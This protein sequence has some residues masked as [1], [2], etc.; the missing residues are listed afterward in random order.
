MLRLV[1][2]LG[3]VFAG[4]ACAATPPP[5]VAARAWLVADLT[6]GHVL[7][8]RKADERFEPASLTKLMTAYVVFGA[9]HER[10]LALTQQVPVSHHAWRAPGAKMFLDP[11]KPGTVDELIHGMVVQ[12][13]NDASIALAEA[14]AGSEEAFVALMNRDAE[15]LG[16]TNSRFMNASGLPDAQHYSTAEDLYILSA[17]LIR[18]F[19]R[20]YAAYYSQKEYR[21][22]NVT[23]PNRT[24]L[25]WVDP[26]V[27]GVKSGHTEAAGYCL[28][29]SSRRNGRR[30]LSVVLGANSEAGRARESQKLLNWG[31]Q[32]YEAVKLLAANDVVRELD[33]WKGSQ[34]SVKV[35]LNRDLYVSVPKGQSDRLKAQLVSRQPLT[36]P[37]KKDQRVGTLRISFDEQPYAEYPLV[38]LENVGPAGLLGRS[39]D[40]L[41]LWIKRFF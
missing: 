22:N 33:V 25:L 10:K 9:V 35:G 15:R 38:A 27:D 30:L 26:T 8:A 39:W 14:I 12:S 13:A 19:P 36:A 5:S 21:Y 2:F 24:G 3:V 37:L 17:A 1:A 29:A 11:K 18:D 32:F 7:T 4:V 23:Q 16:M 28:I 41:R 34:R 6:S 31:F 40:T 20:E